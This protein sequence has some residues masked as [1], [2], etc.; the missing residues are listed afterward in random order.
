M[1]SLVRSQ[2]SRALLGRHLP[3]ATGSL[4]IAELFYKFGSFSLEAIAF[5]GTW[6]VLDLLY[7]TLRTLVE[8][9]GIARVRQ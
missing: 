5:L 3:T 4:L 6:F 9:E 8:E 2:Q 7:Q 1:Y